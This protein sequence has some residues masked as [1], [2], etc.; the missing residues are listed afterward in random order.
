MNMTDDSKS[1]FLPTRSSLLRRVKDKDDHA[2]WQ[3]FF[4]TYKHLIQGVARKAGLSNEEAKEVAQETFISLSG[5]IQEFCYDPSLGSFKSWLLT[6]VR[7]RIVDQFRKR[8]P[9]WK[10]E[11]PGGAGDSHPGP[12]SQIPD[13]K[14]ADL[15]AL[16]EKEWAQYVVHMAAERV[17]PQ[18]DPG[19]Y[20]IYD[21]CVL[22]EWPAPKIAK[23]LC[24][25]LQT[26]YLAKHRVGKVFEREIRKLQSELEQ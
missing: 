12:L 22:K 9:S 19:H 20:Q 24:V 21:L 5:K 6:I 2:S 10:P 23:D 17:K 13:D 4:E 3:D 8:D 11:I 1:D 18:V 15:D 26:V 7:W 25:T 14:V 16:W